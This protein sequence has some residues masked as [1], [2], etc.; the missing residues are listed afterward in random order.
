VSDSSLHLPILIVEDE[1]KIAQLLADFLHADGFTTHIISDGAA[2]IDFV[3]A[4]ELSFVLLDVMLPNKDGLTLCK[5]IRQF[6]EVPILMLTARVDE[7]DRLMGLGFGADDYVCK[8]FSGREVV[9][10]VKAVLKR[11]DSVRN[12]QDIQE[13]NSSD[14]EVVNYQSISINVG[15]FECSVKDTKVVLTPVEFR[16]LHALM[17]KPGH[18][19]SRETLMSS[20]YADSRIVSHR[21]IDSH[22]KNL[23]S[24]ISM[25]LPCEELIH[26]I[27][28]LGYKIQ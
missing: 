23:R 14:N 16:L 26:T 27:Y 20:C 3:K 17:K 8:P 28:G 4:N 6:C 25:Q 12:T 9:A 13:L 1:I 2:V 11:V 15:R 21:T 7:I 22:M 10:R 24:K 5:E 19:F 18:V